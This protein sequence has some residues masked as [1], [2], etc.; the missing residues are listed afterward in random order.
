MR[1]IGR[2]GLGLLAVVVVLAGVVLVRTFTFKP[3]AGADLSAI[4]VAPPIAVDVARA[5]E[6]LSL[7]VQIPTVRHQDRAEDVDAEWTRLHG[8]LETAYPTAHAAMTRDELASRTLVW[9]WAGSDPSLAPIVL[10]AHQD[11]VPV[12]AGT[13]GDWKHPPFGG[14]VA[15][16]AVW[17][18]GAI[19]DKGSLIGIFEA[20]EALTET[21]LQAEADGDRRLRRR[22]G[23]HRPGRAGG[24]GLSRRP[25]A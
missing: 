25:R 12:T 17:G 2:I 9:T 19:D 1:A 10:M 11:V 22:R 5:A 4:T 8:L 3:A 15:D 18:R 23:G 6:H 24:R 13:E 16:G 20:I 7:A 14:V 21:G